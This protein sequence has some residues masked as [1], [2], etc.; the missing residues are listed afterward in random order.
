MQ[1]VAAT[2]FL[3][4]SLHHAEAGLRDPKGWAS[5]V[6]Y[7]SRPDGYTLFRQEDIMAWVIFTLV[8]LLLV[9]FDNVILHRKAETISFNRAMCYTVFWISTALGFD[10]YIYL[11]RGADAA[12]QWG[13]GYL[14]E[15]MLSVDNL[16]VF[17]LIFNLYG[18]PA[19]LKHKPL[20]WGIV[21]AIFFRMVFF[22]IEEVLMHSFVWM[23]IVFGLFLIYTGVKAAFMDDEE[24]DPRKNPVFIWLSGHI[25]FI[26]GYDQDGAFF[27]KVRKDKKGNLILPLLIDD[28]RDKQRQARR[29]LTPGNT[30]RGTPT[31]SRSCS[32]ARGSESEKETNKAPKDR[33]S[34]S[35]SPASVT[36]SRQADPAKGK[37][38]VYR[39][40]QWFT[41]KESDA[42]VDY[43]WRATVLFLVV[44]CLE[45]TDVIFAVDSV[46]AIVAQIPDLYLAYTACV[47]AMLGLR[48]LFFVIDELIR[49]FSLLS[50]GV[51]AILVFIGIKLILKE[52]IHIPPAVVCFVLVTT[53]STCMIGSL[54]WDR[55]KEKTEDGEAQ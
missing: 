50:Y 28:Q 30:P 54:L 43:E 55:Y 52:W 8:F 2:S 48:A 9:I 11:S 4:E 46:S 36:S 41:G 17:H 14:L 40:D 49:L 31:N 39:S 45:V 21:G 15:W 35:R 51:A 47:F 24:G 19:H 26:N 42:G 7:V 12:F 18:T 5:F 44:V 27:V 1:P 32:P 29:S 37:V 33:A 6:G 23:H 22:C 38:M 10:V 53:L 20:F 3:A 16:F 13:T 25:P 34:R